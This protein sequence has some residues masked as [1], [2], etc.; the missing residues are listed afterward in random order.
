VSGPVEAT[1]RRWSELAH[2]IKVGDAW[3]FVGVFAAFVVAIQVTAWGNQQ[4]ADRI[5]RSR[6][7]RYTVAAVFT[8][9]VTV[10]CWALFTIA[11]NTEATGE[12]LLLTSAVAGIVFFAADGASIVLRQDRREILRA[13]VRQT[14][15]EASS[16]LYAEFVRLRYPVPVALA[17][18]A[19]FTVWGVLISAGGLTALALVDIGNGQDVNAHDWASAYV[20][21]ATLLAFLVAGS[22]GSVACWLTWLSR[23]RRGHVGPGSPNSRAGYLLAAITLAVMVAAASLYFPISAAVQGLPWTAVIGVLFAVAGP[24]AIPFLALIEGKRATRK[25][26]WWSPRG[27]VRM[28]AAA[29]ARGYVAYQL[30]G[31]ADLDALFGDSPVADAR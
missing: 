22:L 5:A 17:C 31:V 9:S 7:S 13:E 21:L 12:Y 27:S 28:G 19:A 29:V 2:T 11:F 26:N 8:G 3:S 4:A 16:V 18:T 15:G 1:Q 24:S 14:I 20:P 10:A 25:R 23:R 30:K 6:S